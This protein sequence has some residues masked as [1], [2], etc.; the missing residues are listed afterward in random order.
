MVVPYMFYVTYGLSRG[1]TT[2]RVTVAK[3]HTLK[4]L[5]LKRITRIIFYIATCCRMVGS[6]IEK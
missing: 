6:W 4:Y 2:K 1:R 3:A 5:L